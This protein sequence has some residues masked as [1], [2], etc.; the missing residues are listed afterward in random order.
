MKYYVTSILDLCRSKKVPSPAQIK[1]S[2]SKLNK[3]HKNLQSVKK[4]LPP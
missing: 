2:E 1:Q 4:Q 3:M